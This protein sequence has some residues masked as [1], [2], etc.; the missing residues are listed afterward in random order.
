MSPQ[1]I[2]SLAMYLMLAD[3]LSIILFY[4]GTINI[5]HMLQLI[6]RIATVV[7]NAV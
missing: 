3:I 4:F 1:D 2:F 6:L 5:K 7:R